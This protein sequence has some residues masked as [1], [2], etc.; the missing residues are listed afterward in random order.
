MSTISK[1]TPCPWGSARPTLDPK[2]LTPYQKEWLGQ[3]LIF[4]KTSPA[5]CSKRYG[6]SVD[7]LRKYKKKVKDKIAFRE[8]QGRPPLVD[9]I[10]K[11]VLVE[12]FKEQ[13]NKRKLSDFVKEVRKESVETAKRAKID[14]TSQINPSF[15]TTRRIWNDYGFK[16][17]NAETGTASRIKAC[18]DWKNMFTYLV[19]NY[20]MVKILFLS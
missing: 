19:A 16:V 13:S 9:D 20:S 3:Q 5:Q 4:G 14:D 11:K 10:S 15:A 12:G 18:A 7:L 6:L 8:N 17:K 1:S 2:L